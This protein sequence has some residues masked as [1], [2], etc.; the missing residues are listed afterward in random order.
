MSKPRGRVPQQLPNDPTINAMVAK[1]QG[2]AILATRKAMKHAM[3][4]V[5]EQ[6]VLSHTM[7]ALWRACVRFEPERGFKFS[8]LGYTSCMKAARQKV[9]IENVRAR[10]IRPKQLVHDQ[11]TDANSSSVVG[12]LIARE[13]SNDDVAF[14]NGLLATESKRD[15]QLIYR[16]LVDGLTLVAAGREVG[17]TRER[18][19]QI[20]TKFELRVLEAQEK[21]AA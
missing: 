10:V 17:V 9:Q 4:H 15:A 20:V 2:L 18:V 8:T 13:D 21:R 5:D 16:Y 3:S 19:R 11:Y 6:D 1:H 14:I 12:Q 7:Y